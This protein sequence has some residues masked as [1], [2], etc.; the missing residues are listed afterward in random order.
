MDALN[1]KLAGAMRLIGVL[2]E[3]KPTPPPGGGY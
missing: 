2:A 3:Q 1:Q